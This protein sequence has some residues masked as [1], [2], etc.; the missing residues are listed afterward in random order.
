MSCDIKAADIGSLRQQI[1]VVLQEDFLFNGSISENITLGDAN[2]T[3]R[4]II[5]AAKLASADDFIREL[6]K[7]QRV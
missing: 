3:A 7:A 4:Q 1:G 6:P 5:T 2:I